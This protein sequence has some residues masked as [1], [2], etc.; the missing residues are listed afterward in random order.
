MTL[1]ALIT[2]APW[3]NSQARP[4]HLLGP[5]VVDTCALARQT[6]AATFLLQLVCQLAQ[7]TTMEMVARSDG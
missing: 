7:N 5:F 4:N 3:L 1:G 2:F 6:E